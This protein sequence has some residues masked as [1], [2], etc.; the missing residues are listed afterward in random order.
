MDI[1][2]AVASR[3]AVRNFT[4]RPVPMETIERVLAAAAWAPSGSNIQPWNIYV[5]TGAALTAFFAWRYWF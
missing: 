2:E 5:V 3:R 4:E 1:Y